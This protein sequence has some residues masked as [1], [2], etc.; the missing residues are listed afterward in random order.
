MLVAHFHQDK[1]SNH[2][3]PSLTGSTST[4]AN[5]WSRSSVMVTSRALN[6]IHSRNGAFLSGVCVCVCVA[7]LVCTC[8]CVYVCERLW[9]SVAELVCTCT[10]VY[11]CERLWVSVAELVCMCTLPCVCVC[12]CVCVCVWQLQKTN[13]GVYLKGYIFSC[14]VCTTVAK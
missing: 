10:C 5:Y 11:V 4:K 3:N 14:D 7:E 12:E 8:T 13:S 9:V 1:V 2:R 6:H